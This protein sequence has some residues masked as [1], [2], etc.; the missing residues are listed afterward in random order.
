MKRLFP[1]MFSDA[2]RYLA[3]DG[4]VEIWKVI[5]LSPDTHP[6]HI[7]LIQFKLIVRDSYTI[8]QHPTASEDTKLNAFEVFYD[9][10][11]GETVLD[12]A[13]TGWKDT[14]RINPKEMATI[15]VPFRDYSDHETTA[16]LGKPIRMTGRYMYHCHIL[17]HEDHEMM[18]PFVVMPPAFVEQMRHAE[19]HMIQGTGAPVAAKSPG[20]YMEPK[21]CGCQEEMPMP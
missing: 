21:L 18:R 7:H 1:G 11:G 3:K 4:D 9:S 20:W 5:N 12:R 17:E 10:P 19:M 2:V 16:N 6:L 8:I 14:I 15:A 13:E